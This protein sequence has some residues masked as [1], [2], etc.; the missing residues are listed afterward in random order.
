[1]IQSGALHVLTRIGLLQY[2]YSGWKYRPR[3]GEL[4]RRA[5]ASGGIELVQLLLD[6]G[7]GVKACEMYFKSALHVA[8]SSGKDEMLTILLDAGA[9]INAMGK[10][11]GTALCAVV[12]TLKIS[13]VTL[14]LD[15]NADPNAG[16]TSSGEPALHVAAST[17]DFKNSEADRAIT[18][19]LVDRGAVIHLAGGDHGSVLHAAINAC[20]F[21][22]N[23]N[24]VL[25]KGKMD[26]IRFLL[27][28]G[29]DV[30][31]MGF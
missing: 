14:L 20:N 29:A 19:L 25:H 21:H 22:K 10:N 12:R 8:A 5:T 9:D 17:I 28:C 30:N 24:S 7:L 15:R 18:R 13:A 11:E 1:L 26:L 3:K 23:A 6:P 16:T 31:T 4:L 27:E 2:G